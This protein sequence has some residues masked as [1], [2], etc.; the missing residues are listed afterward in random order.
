MAKT[1][2]KEVPAPEAAPAI[3]VGEL[4]EKLNELFAQITITEAKC[5]DIAALADF[6]RAYT[7]CLVD[8]Y[9][10]GSRQ[11]GYVEESDALRFIHR[12]L[13]FLA[14]ETFTPNDRAQELARSCIALTGVEPPALGGSLDVE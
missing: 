14:D 8:G 13:R 7:N 3:D 6:T 11:K 9:K 2:L 4:S 1:A 5:R 12:T 10:P